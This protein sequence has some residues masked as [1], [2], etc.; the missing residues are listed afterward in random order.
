MSQSLSWNSKMSQF[1]QYVFCIILRTKYGFTRFADHCI[2]LS[3]IQRPNFF[4]NRGCKY[5]SDEHISPYFHMNISVC[6]QWRYKY[7]VP[8]SSVLYLTEHP[9][10]F[11]VVLFK[12]ETVTDTQ[13]GIWR[14]S[15]FN[16]KSVIIFFLKSSEV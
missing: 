10:L 15:A 11:L 12:S 8:L 9:L 7:A 13:R 6:T 1:T 2:L 4:W 14:F 5:L 3:F 16:F